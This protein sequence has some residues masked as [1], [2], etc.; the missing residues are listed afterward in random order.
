MNND[1]KSIPATAAIWLINFYRGAISPYKRSR[2][3]FEPTCSRYAILAIQ[4]YGFLKGGAKAIRRI[5]RCNPFGGQGYD[6]P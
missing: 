1:R 4:K 6:M 3:R 5:L 2:C